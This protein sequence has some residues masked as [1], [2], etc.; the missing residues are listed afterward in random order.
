MRSV[1]GIII[2]LAVAIGFPSIA[3]MDISRTNPKFDIINNPSVEAV[4]VFILVAAAV[5]FACFIIG[6]CIRKE[7]VIIGFF[8]GAFI[9]TFIWGAVCVCVMLVFWLFG[10]SPDMF[11][12][13]YPNNQRLAVAIIDGLF[14]IPIIIDIVM[15]IKRI[16]ER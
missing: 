14:L 3:F 6:L 5:Y 10:V 11:T 15:A 7:G 13:A 9:G 1:I 2:K 8:A 16:R 12:D 4:L